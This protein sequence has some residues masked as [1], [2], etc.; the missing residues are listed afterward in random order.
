MADTQ[1][2]LVIPLG[3]FRLFVI[4]A[5]EVRLHFLCNDSLTVF[6]IY[7]TYLALGQF[8][9]R[10]RYLSKAWVVVLL[11]FFVGCVEVCMYCEY[12]FLKARVNAQTLRPQS[13]KNFMISLPIFMSD[14]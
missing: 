4:K 6:I 9:D 14:K 3:Q 8:R 13:A 7:H 11:L 5:L 12:S 1:L 2:G 10:V